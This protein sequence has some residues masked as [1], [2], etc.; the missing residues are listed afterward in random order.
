MLVRI[1][2]RVSHGT[3]GARSLGYEHLLWL[4]MRCSVNAFAEFGLNGLRC[5]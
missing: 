2:G 3:A 4:P 5:D 1:M